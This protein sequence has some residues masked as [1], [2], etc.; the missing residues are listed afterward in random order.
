DSSDMSR[1]NLTDDA[2]TIAQKI[3]RAKSDSIEGINYDPENRPEAANLLTIFAALRG[4]SR[5]RVEADYAAAQFS[6]FKT[7]LADL[8]VAKLAPIAAEM[9]KL[10]D[11]PAEID[12]LLAKGAAR[13]AARAQ[14][15]LREVH[16][17]I[18][19]APTRAA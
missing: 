2:D 9:R 18:G 11:D 1:I 10:L 15:V 13:A 12:R 5:E 6:T 17:I 7:D 16:E 8:A 14:T 4:T 3:R 19:F